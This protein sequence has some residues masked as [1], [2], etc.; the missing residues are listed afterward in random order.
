MNIFFFT[1]SFFPS[2]KRK[3]KERKTVFQKK[4]FDTQRRF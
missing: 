3:M 1:F 2:E 4:N